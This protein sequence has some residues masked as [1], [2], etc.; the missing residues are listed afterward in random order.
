MGMFGS[1][2]ELDIN[3]LMRVQELLAKKKTPEMVDID[4][5]LANFDGHTFFSI[6]ND[7]EK[8][9]EQVLQQL[10]DTDL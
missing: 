6:F 8:F 5:T 9:T 2:C 3:E 10:R 1:Y 7:E 4:S